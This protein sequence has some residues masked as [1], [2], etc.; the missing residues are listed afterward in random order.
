MNEKVHIGK[1]IQQKMEEEGR[2]VS[3]LANKIGCDESNI[4]RIYGQQFPATERVIRICIALNFNF[5]SHYS[6][7]V[8]QQIQDK[9]NKN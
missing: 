4:Y 3:W 1:L 8:L 5:F 6:E 7:Y 9:N 2:K